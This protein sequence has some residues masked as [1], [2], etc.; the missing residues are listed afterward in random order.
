M[1][2]QILG[3]RHR[4]SSSALTLYDFSSHV[5]VVNPPSAVQM[6]NGAA[7]Q[8][9]KRV[10]LQELRNRA[11]HLHSNI[12]NIEQQQAMLNSQRSVMGEAVFL[13]KM[14][15]AEQ[16]IARKRAILTK[17]NMMLSVNGLPAI[18]HGM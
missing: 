8:D 10:A 9:S 1:D 2:P 18:G 11:L 13:Q 16:D 14:A 6:F 3:N 17:W 5:I 15:I 7:S 4:V 12:K